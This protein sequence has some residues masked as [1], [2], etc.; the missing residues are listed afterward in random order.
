MVQPFLRC[1]PDV[2]DVTTALP[3]LTRVRRQRFTGRR[4]A[5]GRGAVPIAGFRAD[6]RATCAVSAL[7]RDGRRA[8]AAHDS[9]TGSSGPVGMGGSGSPREVWPLGMARRTPVGSAP[10]RGGVPR[11]SLWIHRMVKSHIDLAAI[12]D[13]GGD[14]GEWPRV[15]AWRAASRKYIRGI[16]CQVGSP[17][18]RSLCRHTSDDCDEDERSRRQVRPGVPQAAQPHTTADHHSDKPAW[19]GSLQ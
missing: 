1:I 16:H 7:A 14:H 11:S 10:T 8:A 12:R 6:S 4:A 13:H 9:A 2:E 17:H 15:G 19:Q 5:G 18:L 3:T